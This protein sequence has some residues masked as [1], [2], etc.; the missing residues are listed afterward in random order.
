VLSGPARER[1]QKAPIDRV[2]VTNSIPQK[3]DTVLTKLEVVN[4]AVLI[5]E[6]IHRIHN[7]LSVSALF[8]PPSGDDLE[9]V[10]R[11]LRAEQ[12]VTAAKNS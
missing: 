12:L 4:I 10:S 2:I 6:A 3:E 7:Y 8:D 5:A 11:V 1:L 9:D